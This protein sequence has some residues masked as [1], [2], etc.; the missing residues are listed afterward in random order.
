MYLSNES[1]VFGRC[2][3]PNELWVP[4]IEKAYAKLHGCYE[5]LISGF[6]DDAL[7]DMTGY[8]SEKLNLHDRNGNFPNPSLPMKSH[9][10]DYIHTW[11]KEGSMMGCAWKTT[12]I[13]EKLSNGIITGHA[14]GI[15]DVLK[16]EKSG[17]ET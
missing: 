10:F 4:L 3:D 17:H 7:H 8:V 15:T 14:Y 1:P 12:A 11:W 6:L 16:I 13:E 2:S 9:F 5:T